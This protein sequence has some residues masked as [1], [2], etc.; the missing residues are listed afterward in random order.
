MI[1]SASTLDRA[2]SGSVTLGVAPLGSHGARTVRGS[3]P[4]R[5]IASATSRLALSARARSRLSA[6]SIVR[7][8][9]PASRGGRATSRASA[10]RSVAISGPLAHRRERQ[11][12]GGRGA[13]A[14]L[15]RH[16]V[17]GLGLAEHLEQLARA[18]HRLL[19][20]LSISPRV[21]HPLSP[22]RHEL[23]W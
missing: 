2:L 22:V 7:A 13:Q 23:S 11:Q 14:L 1:A 3:T 9:I 21:G 15:D 17:Q 12:I 5:S 6:T 4:E 10:S 16:R 19:H 20:A 8:S 18:I